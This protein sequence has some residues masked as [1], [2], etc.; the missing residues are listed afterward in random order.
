MPDTTAIWALPL[1]AAAPDPPVIWAVLLIAAAIVLFFVEIL[2][3]TGG[4]L[5]LLAAA[6]LVTGIVLLFYENTTLGLIG[7]LASLIALPI[8]IGFGLRILPNTPIFK[9]LTLSDQQ[10]PVRT[11]SSGPAG[12]DAV[13]VGDEGKVITELRLVG[14]VQIKGRRVECLSDQGIVQT[15]T[16]VRVVAVDGM[17]VKVKAAEN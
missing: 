1:L 11:K 12:D 6:T 15:G 9:L 16:A 5:G 4:L 14:L 3:P 8:V 2:V 10:E 13:A 17:H 7:T